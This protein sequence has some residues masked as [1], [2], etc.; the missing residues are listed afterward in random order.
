LV[1]FNESE[2]VVLRKLLRKIG[3]VRILADEET[4]GDGGGGRGADEVEPPLLPL[5]CDG[6]EILI[7]RRWKKLETISIVV[8]SVIGIPFGR[9]EA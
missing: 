4:C 7:H 3:F 9:Y 6:V 8:S 2:L 5:P 1:V